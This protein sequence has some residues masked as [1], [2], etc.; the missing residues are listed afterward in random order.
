MNITEF[1]APVMHGIIDRRILVNFR[2]QPEVVRP[3]LPPK[4]R[5][6]LVRGWAIAGICLIRLKDLRPPGLPSAFGLNSEN[7][8]HRIAVEWNEDGVP[9]EGVFVPR[10]DTSSTLQ[11][12]AGGRVFPGPHGL[13]DFKAIEAG[14]E[15]HVRM[16]SRD[17]VTRVEILA[18]QTPHWP[19][20]SIFRSLGEASRFF[21]TGSVGYSPA[22]DPGCCEALELRTARWEVEPLHAV[23]VKSSFFDDRDR[24]P[25]DSLHFD[26]VLLMRNIE[27]EW[28]PL[29]RMPG[30]E[31]P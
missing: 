24:F 14:G 29:P 4:F 26:C 30:F 7:A 13:A 10:R 27:H 1:A 2:V 8:A 22:G 3:L 31:T 9:R 15:Y 6:K 5:P 21:E 11:S 28:H 25:A 20:K 18:R 23:V 12:W 16:R 19:A 17:G